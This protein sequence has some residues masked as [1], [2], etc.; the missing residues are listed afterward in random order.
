M[1]QRISK[2]YFPNWDKYATITS[3]YGKGAFVV[4][5]AFFIGKRC[6]VRQLNFKDLSKKLPTW[7][8]HF[9]PEQAVCTTW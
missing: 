2:H 5:F 1:A 3:I 4:S 8:S 7:I 6:I 9:W